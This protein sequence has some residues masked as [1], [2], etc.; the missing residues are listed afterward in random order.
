MYRIFPELVTLRRLR[1]AVMRVPDALLFLDVDPAVSMERIRSR[2]EDR[3]V[4]ETEEKL[5]RLRDGYRM[6]CR[7]VERDLGIP[8][9]ILDGGHD[10]A[11]VAAMALEELRRMHLPAFAHLTG[12]EEIGSHG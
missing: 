11:S 10:A 2:G 7:V 3:Q 12:L 1:L 8:A 6:V 5:G 4:H 9:G